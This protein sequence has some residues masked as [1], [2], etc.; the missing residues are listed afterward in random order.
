[1]AVPSKPR[2]YALLFVQTVGA[3]IVIAG[4]ICY[5]INVGGAKLPPGINPRVIVLEALI[6][7][8]IV[9]PGGLNLFGLTVRGLGRNKVENKEPLA[10][11]PRWVRKLV[12]W[13]LYVDLFLLLYL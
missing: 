7:L 2:F 8:S 12:W 5:W 3:L 4:M 10:D 11:D 1:M 13:Y 9:I 6:V